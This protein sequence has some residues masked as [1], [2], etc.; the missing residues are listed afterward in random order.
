MLAGNPTRYH[1]LLVLL[2]LGA[3]QPDDLW[4]DQAIIAPLPLGGVHQGLLQRLLE[5]LLAQ[6]AAG[7]YAFSSTM[8]EQASVSSG[9]QGLVE[10]STDDCT[11][12]GFG[13]ARC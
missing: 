7:R 9:P 8:G 6:M 12:V 11:L 2:L 5:T 3:L 10:R 13:Q 4:W 1:P